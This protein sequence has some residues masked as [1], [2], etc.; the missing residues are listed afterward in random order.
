M[1][2]LENE[3]E[4]EKEQFINAVRIVEDKLIKKVSVIPILEARQYINELYIKW[5]RMQDIHDGYVYELQ[6]PTVKDLDM[7]E[8]WIEEIGSALREVEVKLHRHI[9]KHGLKLQKIQ[10]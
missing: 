2:E 7:E 6:N 3:R 5:D 10:L 8:L 1:T 9:E 4:A